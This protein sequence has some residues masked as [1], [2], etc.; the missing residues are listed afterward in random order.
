MG[1][2]SSPLNGLSFD[3]KGEPRLESSYTLQFVGDWGLANFHRI[4]SW[5]TQGF[6]DRAGPGTRT[7]IWSLTDGGMAALQDVQDRK[8]DLAIATP[9][10]ILTKAATGQ[11]I[12]ANRPMPNLRALGKLPQNDRMVLALS[13]SYGI[14]TMEEL[15]AKKPPL[16]LVT[17][18][19]D[20]T[21]FI[22][23]VGTKYLEA[24]GISRETIKS[25]GGKVLT[26]QRPEQCT[27]MVESGEADALLQEA[28]MTP[29]W[30][31]LIESETLVPLACE[32]QTYEN[33]E[34]ELSLGPNS[35]P[36]GFWTKLQHELPALDFSDF[37]VIVRDDMPEEVAY[38]LSWCLV[39]TRDLIEVQYKHLPPERSPLSYP[40]NPRKMAQTPIPLHP[41][42]QRYYTDAGH[43]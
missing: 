5:L 21:N 18:V 20:G 41:G 7:S 6:A 14:K 34:K 28:I 13:P 33:L 23:Y 16:R 8:V 19:D 26:A 37:V 3:Q 42:A 29:W 1:S 32:S 9:A 22:G 43:L 12:F 17:S 36:L 31:N 11:A 15:R 30:R 25:W 40:L 27:A 4:C 24:H 39:E 38:L 10:G 2:H 35:L